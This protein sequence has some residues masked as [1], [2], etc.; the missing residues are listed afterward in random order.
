MKKIFTLYLISYNLFLFSQNILSDDSIKSM[1]KAADIIFTAFVIHKNIISTTYDEIFLIDFDITEIQKGKD[2]S[3]LMVYVVKDTINFEKGKEYLVFAKKS[4]EQNNNYVCFFA[5]M[6]CKSC[7][8]FTIKK[9]YQIVD[10]RPFSTI[11]KP[12]SKTNYHQRG[13]GCF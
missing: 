13:C 5:E 3:R 1:Y 2:Y 4:K 12:R 8:N 7:T 10:K 11:K 6:V 9:I